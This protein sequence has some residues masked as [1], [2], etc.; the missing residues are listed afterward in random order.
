[1]VVWRSALIVATLVTATA[2]LLGLP[3]PI[4]CSL[5]MSVA[6]PSLGLFAITMVVAVRKNGPF[7]ILYAYAVVA[8][9]GV[10]VLRLCGT[11]NVALWLSLLPLAG[12]LARNG[13]HLAI[14]IAAAGAFFGQVFGPY[15]MLFAGAMAV[16]DVF[17]VKKVVKL[18]ESFSD[19]VSVRLPEID[20]GFGDFA[21]YGALA[22]QLVGYG[23][24]GV[25]VAFVSIALGIIATEL[26]FLRR[27]GYGPALPMPV[28][29]LLLSKIVY[30]FH[31]HV[32]GS[33]KGRRDSCCGCCSS[34]RR[35]NVSTA[36]PV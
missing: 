23:L 25:I 33:K 34:Y 31:V 8:G 36:G 1:M 4:M 27:L 5:S 22:S 13:L 18:V 10:I 9:L 2:A 20:L 11:L 15:A 3:P 26:L 21:V 16:V 28:A 17:I 12:L 29:F 7:A 6:I 14:F 24:Y 30:F 32:V 19:K 35:Y